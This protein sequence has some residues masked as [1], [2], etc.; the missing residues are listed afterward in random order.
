MIARSGK[1]RAESG[2]FSIKQNRILS[3]VPKYA[4]LFESYDE[5][6]GAS[7]VPCRRQCTD[8]QMA[9]PPEPDEQNR[10]LVQDVVSAVIAA[11]LHLGGVDA[12][13]EFRG[14]DV[15]ERLARS[16]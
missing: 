7:G 16:G 14:T 12:I 13:I 10:C 15:S 4:A 11:S 1:R 6:V 3:K 9:W 5:A 2:A 8:V